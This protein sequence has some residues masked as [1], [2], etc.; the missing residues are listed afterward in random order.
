MFWIVPLVSWVCA[1]AVYGNALGLELN[2]M[3]IVY[4][5]VGFLSMISA[6]TGKLML[7]LIGAILSELIS[8]VYSL[9]LYLKKKSGGEE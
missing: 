7:P 1:A 5:L 3:T 2:I 6:F 9:A 8:I 4:V